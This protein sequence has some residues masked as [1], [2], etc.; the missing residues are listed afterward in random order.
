MKAAPWHGL[1][2]VGVPLLCGMEHQRGG[3]RSAFDALPSFLADAFQYEVEEGVFVRVCGNLRVRCV[4]GFRED[5]S[6]QMVT[7][8]RLPEIRT[9]GE[10]N[11]HKPNSL[12]RSIYY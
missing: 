9:G 7:F 5:K 10:R 3:Q 1:P 4:G 6:G 12:L 8:C 11:L 2:V